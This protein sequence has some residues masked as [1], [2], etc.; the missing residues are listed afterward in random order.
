MPIVFCCC[1]Q[2]SMST[3]IKNIYT[4]FEWKVKREDLIHFKTEEFKWQIKSQKT[5]EI[6][7]PQNKS[8]KQLCFLCIHTQPQINSMKMVNY[9]YWNWLCC[10]VLRKLYH[11]LIFLTFEVKQNVL[12][13]LGF[14]VWGKNILLL[15]D[16]MLNYK[17]PKIHTTKISTKGKGKKTNCCLHNNLL[18]LPLSEYTVLQDPSS[19][20]SCTLSSIVS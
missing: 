13:G 15:G 4:S 6:Q 3:F 10:W 18:T 9:D 5:W 12:F 19:D 17:P 2:F 1:C 11:L 20:F 14:F 8:C 7:K 16:C